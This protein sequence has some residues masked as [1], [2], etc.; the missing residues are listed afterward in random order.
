MTDNSRLII[1]ALEATNPGL[2]D[3]IDAQNSWETAIRTRGARVAKYRRY[4]RGNH[5]ANLTDQM[6]AMLRLKDDTA[7]LK[8]FN[9]NYMRII[10]DKM[11]AR[12]HI[13][14]ITSDDEATDEWI[15]AL[16]ELNDWD[17][18]QGELYRG[19]IRDAD[20]YV[21]IDIRTMLWVAEPAYDGFSGIVSIFDE[22]GK[23]IWACKLWSEA[24]NEDLTGDTINSA[25][26]TMKLVVFQPNEISFWKGTEGS[27]GLQPVI[28][29]PGIVVEGVAPTNIRVWPVGEIPLV[30][31]V[32][33]KDNYTAFGESELR[34]AIP[35]QDALNRTLHS[36]IMASEFSAFQ[37]LWAIGMELDVDGIT[38]GSVLNMVFKDKNGVV[39]TDLKPEQIEFLKAVKVGV[40]EGTDITQYTNQ[41]EHL[42]KEI[43]QATQT[44]IYGITAQGNVSGDAL[45]QLEVGLIGK[46]QRFQREN[47]AEIRRL[48]NLTAIVQDKFGT[49]SDLLPA[50]KVGMIAI[51]WMSPEIL[52]VN[53][54]IV[55][56]VQM[57]KDAP[58]LFAD[59]WFRRQIGGLLGMAQNK[60]A[61][62]GE[63]VKNQRSLNL[64]ALTGGDGTIPV[65]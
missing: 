46:I 53:A 11:A 28:Q 45:R 17:S 22:A 51:D 56:L 13:S 3:S 12:L 32:N 37:I 25:L 5:D 49:D 44:P 31:L 47:T 62:E 24:D 43:S 64:L 6:Q 41:I 30:H 7:E 60:I 57:R 40:F 10:V 18:L 39:T 16:L 2:A 34:P 36:M 33:Q 63:I 38:P 26:V 58:G 59:D 55:T 9:D 54:Q 29:D 52:D 4:E 21:L 19:A 15:D 42:V 8:E 27:A 35:L 1:A 23:S 50:P 48:I 61:E 14:S 65:A 20:S